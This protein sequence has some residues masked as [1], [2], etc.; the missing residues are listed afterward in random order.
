LSQPTLR[1]ST[2]KFESQKQEVGQ[3]RMRSGSVA[4]STLSTRVVPPSLPPPLF[5]FFDLRMLKYT[6]WYTTLGRS[7]NT[8]CSLLVGPHQ[9]PPPPPFSPLVL[10][11]GQQRM[12]A[13]SVASSALS[14]RVVQQL[15]YRNVQRFRG[16]LVFKAHRLLYH[17]TLGLRVI[18]KKKTVILL[19]ACWS[20]PTPDKTMYQWFG[21]PKS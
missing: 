5:S 6:R 8:A 11:K 14:T 13:G 15:L 17:S 10:S 4:S 12:R 7:Q 1:L 20:F 16:G 9:S 21:H 3:Q 18:K 19:D 2:P